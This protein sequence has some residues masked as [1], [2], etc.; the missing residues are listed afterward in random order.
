MMKSRTVLP[1]RFATVAE[2]EDK[3]KRILERELPRFA[4]MLK[5]M[6][7]KKELGLKAI[8]KENIYSDILANY[9]QIKKEK[10]RI[11]KGLFR[12]LALVDIGRQ[13]EAALEQE[14]ERYKHEILDDLEPLSL[15]VKLNKTYGERMI[16]NGAFLVGQE[17]EASFDRKVDEIDDRYKGKVHFKYVVTPPFNFVTIEI[18]TRAY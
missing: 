7:G 6:E 18:D 5:R 3:V 9:D 15:E 2:T 11:A 13:V 16:L 12:E 14:K 10:E 1:V 8:F 4:E 17:T